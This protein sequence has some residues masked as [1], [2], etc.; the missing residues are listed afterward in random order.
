[1]QGTFTNEHL[2]ILLIKRS[3]TLISKLTLHLHKVND[4]HYIPVVF[5]YRVNQLRKWK[6]RQSKLYKPNTRTQNQF[7]QECNYI[8]WSCIEFYIN[9]CN[10]SRI[11]FMLPISWAY[12]PTSIQTLVKRK[13]LEQYEVKLYFCSWAT[14]NNRI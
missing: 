3:D 13:I 1:M 5:F 2:N 7:W 11:F 12:W 14:T 9:I 8:C 10:Y 4:D 6:Q